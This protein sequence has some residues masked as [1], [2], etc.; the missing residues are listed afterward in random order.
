VQFSQPK[1]EKG[2][3][4]VPLDPRTVVALREHAER[5]AEEQ[6]LLGASVGLD[7]VFSR[8]D[9][10]P[11]HPH[12]FSQAFE[13]RTSEA[14]LPRIRLHDLRHT[15]AT[16]ALQQGHHPKVVSEILGHSSVSIT[17]YTYSHA[18]PMLNETAVAM[19]ATLVLG[20][21][22]APAGSPEPVE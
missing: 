6:A 14:C 10:A 11:L 13:Q 17:L 7:L 16:L 1:T 20:D 8:P 22:A 18:I 2:R 4:S 21:E 3:R 15:W 19:V 9:G 5:Q 12:Q